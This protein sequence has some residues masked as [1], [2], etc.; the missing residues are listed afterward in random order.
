MRRHR[1]TGDNDDEHDIVDDRA[2]TETI[3]STEVS[4]SEVAESVHSPNVIVCY[5]TYSGFDETFTEYLK[6]EDEHSAAN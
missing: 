2:T 3:E 4:R 6:D 1:K 5:K